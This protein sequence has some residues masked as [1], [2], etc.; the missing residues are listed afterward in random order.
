M[1][2]R[3]V[4][5]HAESILLWPLGGL[6]YIGHNQGPKADMWVA[7]AG[8]L[9]HVPMT[10]FWVCMLVAATYVAYGTT[11]ISL[12]WPWPL[13]VH[14]LGVAVCSGA[15]VLNISLFAFNLLVPAYPLD[16]GRILVDSLLTCG[17]AERTTAVV[18]CCVATPIAVG[19]IIWGC[20]Q[21]Q[22]ITILVGLW[23]LWSTYQLFD[24]Y[25][26]GLLAQHPMFA[27]TAQQN[28]AAGGNQ[29]QLPNPFAQQA[30]PDTYQPPA[31]TVVQGYPVQAYPPNY[32]PGRV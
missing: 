16:G 11:S 19:I 6:A 3:Q 4:G 15:V 20:V 2:A 17:V 22:V 28:A 24:C 26:K 7:L 10:I 32:P 14:N 25:R 31:A 9:T 1:A 5:G 8:P 27:F 18:T 29:G 30:A 21:F 23:I 13:T 12:G